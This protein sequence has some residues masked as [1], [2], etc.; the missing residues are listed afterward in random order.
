M[1]GHNGLPPELAALPS[2]ELRAAV[3]AVLRDV[4]PAAVA[5]GPRP[6]VAEEVTLA[7]GADLD[8]FVRHVATLCEDPAQRSA[9]RDGRRR[10]RLAGDGS[11]TD[12][13]RVDRG[14][15]T[16]RTVR[17]AAAAGARLVVGPRAVLT[18][19]ARDSARSLGGRVDREER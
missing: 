13:V 1:S 10:F 14:A 6:G 17:K 19:L 4:L 15:I 16:E 3:R 2:D 18:P 11:D 5:T 8:S 9:L 7:T 12:V